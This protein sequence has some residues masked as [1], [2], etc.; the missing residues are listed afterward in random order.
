MVARFGSSRAVRSPD[1]SLL[2]G[3]GDRPRWALSRPPAARPI[4]VTGQSEL[5]LLS[6]EEELLLGKQ[7]FAELA[8]SAGRALR[9]D[10]ATQAYLDGIVRKLHQV[11]HR[12]NL[13][14]D[15][16]L[17]SASE[18]NAWAIPAIPP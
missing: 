7:A 9:I 15:F 1:A 16:T 17:E 11:S 2:Q 3:L 4:P 18:P 12:S 13:P 6:E 10:P 8:W 14:V 5:M